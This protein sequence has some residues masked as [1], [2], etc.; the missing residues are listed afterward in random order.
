MDL[1]IIQ[2]D[3]SIGSWV[4]VVWFLKFGKIWLRSSKIWRNYIEFMC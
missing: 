2:M 1:L 3:F 4:I